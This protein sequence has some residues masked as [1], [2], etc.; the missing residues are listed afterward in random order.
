MYTP[1]IHG[2]EQVRF[3]AICRGQGAI[4][5]G[6]ARRSVPLASPTELQ[7]CRTGGTAL[8][9]VSLGSNNVSPEVLDPNQAGGGQ[10]GQVDLSNHVRRLERPPR[11]QIL[12]LNS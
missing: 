4:V 6:S 12:T 3:S 8:G 11:A 10:Q 2:G 7:A 9:M 5:V 1:S